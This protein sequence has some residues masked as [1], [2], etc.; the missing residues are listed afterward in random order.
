[1]AVQGL[2]R[3]TF[4]GVV[5]HN[6]LGGRIASSSSRLPTALA[7]AARTYATA[8]TAMLTPGTP[9]PQSKKAPKTVKK[10]K[11]AVS[12]SAAP[13]AADS[14]KIFQELSD[15][16]R[17]KEMEKM[18]AMSELMPTVDPWGQVIQ[19]TL[20]VMIPYDLSKSKSVD[21][22]NH[23]FTNWL[24]N[25]TA[26]RT[27]IQMNAV[28]D[29][30]FPKLGE[31]WW[32]SPKEKLRRARAAFST[33]S[34]DENALLASFR[35]EMLEQYIT[36]NQAVVNRNEKQVLKLTTFQYQNDMLARMKS[37]NKIARRMV[38]NLH[39]TLSPV[40]VVSLRTTEGYMAQEPPRFGNRLMIHA[41]VKF[42]TEQ[43]LEL[44]NDRGVA[45]HPAAEDPDFSPAEKWRIPAQ[46]KR[47]TEYLVLERRGWIISPWQFREQMW[48]SS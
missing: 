25:H 17:L 32:D 5:A 12:K 24:K 44:Y 27:L 35:S 37:T 30:H 3:A 15:V 13:T 38:W 16:D 28:P 4:V 23:N 8:N 14:S 10:I 2:S 21:K 46:R 19:E 36:L 48:Q 39:K 20:D 40:E 41:L 26:L 29:K 42:D 6:A 11:Q 1:M 31:R 9:A 43:S 7:Y 18:M 47:V 45:L 33:R 22:M 34:L